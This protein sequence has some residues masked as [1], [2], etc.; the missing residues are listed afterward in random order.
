MVKISLLSLIPV[1]TGDYGRR[2]RRLS[3]NSATNCRRLRRL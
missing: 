2:F 3:P 1:H